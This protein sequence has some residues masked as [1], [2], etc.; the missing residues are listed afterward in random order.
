MFRKLY[1]V[2]EKV[3]VKGKSEVLGVYTSIPNLI[4]HCLEVVDTH[5]LRIS[6]TKLDSE[7]SLLGTWHGPEFVGLLESVSPF[8]ATDEFSPD[9]VQALKRSIE[10]GQPLT[11]S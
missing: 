4:R 1:W 5:T 10:S 2:A 7:E 8:V 6:L 9:Q 3:S 11:N